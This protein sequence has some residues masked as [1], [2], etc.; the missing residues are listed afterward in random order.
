MHPLAVLNML[1]LCGAATLIT[2]TESR[3]GLADQCWHSIRH[4]QSGNLAAPTV[5]LPPV[6]DVSPIGR[7]QLSRRSFV[8]GGLSAL[9]TA[10]TSNSERESSGL[11]QPSTPSEPVPELWATLNS[12][13]GVRVFTVAFSPD[14]DTLASG[15]IRKTVDLWDVQTKTLT[16]SPTFIDNGADG[17]AGEQ[18]LAVQSLAY[19]PSGSTLA[20]GNSDGSITLWDVGTRGKIAILTDPERPGPGEDEIWSVAFSP[21]GALLASGNNI[22]PVGL[23]D[24]ASRRRVAAL[25]GHKDDYVKAVTFSPDGTLLATASAADYTVRLWDVA[26]RKNISTLKPR[27]FS[28][29]IVSVAFS[30]DGAMLASGAGTITLWDVSSRKVAAILKGHTSDLVMSLAFSPDGSLLASGGG[31]KTVRLWDLGKTRNIATLVQN[32]WVS[33]VTFS[34]DGMML[35][36]ASQYDVRLW[37]LKA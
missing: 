10:C 16:A 30:S 15:G 6:G 4:A 12:G 13:D 22:G 2:M 21:D 18:P 29:S 9:A 32:D 33:S 5:P 25:K 27:P 24:V 8:L 36:S 37:R 7:H 3:K 20:S 1:L 14:G 19:S 31:D 34:P 11:S 26:S 28:G 17:Y 35:A 23:W